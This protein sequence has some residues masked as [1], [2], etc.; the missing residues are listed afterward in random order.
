MTFQIT[1]ANG[2]LAVADYISRLPDGHSYSVTITRSSQTAKRSIRQNALYWKWIGIIARET[3][4]DAD[5]VSREL[6]RKFLGYEV[7]DVLGREVEVVHGTH[8]LPKERFTELLNAVE[9]F[10]Y[11]FLGI[12]LPHPEDAYFEQM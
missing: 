11:S 4:N 12:I 9:A 5:T 10:A 8:N 7:R 3:G 1:D 2:R 6:C